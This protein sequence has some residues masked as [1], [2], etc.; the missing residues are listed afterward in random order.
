MAPAPPI[1]GWVIDLDGVVWRGRRTVPGAV[2]AVA[3][4]RAAGHPVLFVT[5]NSNRTVDMVEEKLAELGIDARGCVL[6]S[7]VAAADL[8]QPGERVLVCG[9][10]GVLDAVLSRGAVPVEDGADVVVVG[11][12]EEFDYQWLTK[13]MRAIRAGARFVATN[14][15]A[16][17]PAEDGLLPGNGAL[18]AAVRAASGVEPVVAGKPHR[19]LCDAVLRRLGPRGVVVG[20]RWDTD[21]RFAA[22]LGYRFALV[23]SGVTGPGDL[24]A[25]A[26]PELLAPDLASVVAAWVGPRTV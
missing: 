9:G 26:E 17:F 22:A 20:D 12:T 23:L 3:E 18:V 2:D 15:D 7:A 10:P 4:L 25:G 6:T 14:S 1:E 24:P 5:N 16:T 11:I 13:A 19:P 8:I 21:G